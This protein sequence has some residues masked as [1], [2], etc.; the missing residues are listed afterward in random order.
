MRKTFPA[1]LLVFLMIFSTVALFPGCAAPVAE[2]A[3]TQAPA[4]APEPAQ[5]TA[6][7]ETPAAAPTP[8]GLSGEITF[9]FWDANQQDGMQALVDAFT[10]KN[11]GVKISLSVTP[12]NQYWQVLGAAAEGGMPD[13]FWMH[14]NNF[15][16]FAKKDL[17]MDCTGL[18]DKSMFPE[19]ISQVFQWEGK[20]L[21]VPKDFDT[22]ALV[23]NKDLFDAAGV[24]YP[25]D[26]WN[27]D[28]LVDAAKKL[29][30]GDVYGFGANAGEDQSGYLLP[31][32]Q[33]GGYTV[34]FGEKKSGY[35]DPKSIEGM[36]FWVDL[37]KKYKVSPTQEQ[38]SEMTQHDY[39]KSG[40]LAMTFLG[41]WEIKGYIDAM[42]T[43]GQRFD[44]A[45]MPMGPTGIRATIYNGLT[46]AG[47]KG[48]KQPEIVK[49]FLT[50][51]GTKEAAEIMGKSGAAIPAYQDTQDSW[52]NNFPEV[53]VK[54]YADMI[55]YGVQYPFSKT[56]AEWGTE[57][58]S[59]VAEMYNEKSPD[60][61]AEMAKIAQVVEGYLA[62]E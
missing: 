36:Q 46:Y 2:P 41:S 56:K 3:E 18:Y 31:I 45:V 44:V 39:F 51:L 8:E 16:D 27:W 52:Y 17:L 55:S 60:V 13:V 57:E 38:F 50:F 35:T 25:D 33:A 40:K 7:A 23:Y 58:K 28:S 34:K 12:W 43:L 1:L 49:S 59:M 22:I 29:T 32:Y 37:Q 15:V 21:G 48:T 42:K 14:S 20:Q 62:Q 54:V 4:A 11:P 19:G 47:Y 5:T 53:N 6:P 24:K 30:K 61:A 10:A 9:A 26:T